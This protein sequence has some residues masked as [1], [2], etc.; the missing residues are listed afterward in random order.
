MFSKAKTFR[1]H[2]RTLR[3]VILKV[4]MVGKVMFLSSHASTHASALVGDWQLSLGWPTVVRLA[5]RW[6]QPHRWLW[7][8]AFEKC[9]SGGV[10]GA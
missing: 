3:F 8:S 9:I 7:H 5:W 2:F 6:A 1:G 10:S 4:L